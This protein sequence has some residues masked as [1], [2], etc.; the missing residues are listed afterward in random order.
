MLYNK[1]K[2][3][4]H[5]IS[6]M[7]REGAQ[8]FIMNI[9]RNID[10]EKIQ[11]D[12]LV[13]T[14][15]KC[16]YDDEIMS[17]GG[18]IFRIE[19]VSKYNVFKYSSKVSKT[20]NEKGPFISIHSHI[21]FFNGIIMKGAYNSKIPVRIAHSHSISDG[22]KGSCIRSLYKRYMR[23]LILKYSTNL[24]GCSTKACEYLYGNQ[25]YSDKRVKVINNGIEL[26]KYK[27][28][29]GN[30]H[31]LKERL[32]FTKDTL[33]IGHVGRF[34]KP[35][36]HLFII[37]IF[38]DLFKKNNK[39]KLILVGDGNLKKKVQNKIIEKGLEKD[40]LLLGIRKD[41]PQIMGALDVFLLPS[42]YEGLGIVLVE[43][44]SAGIPCIT[45]NTVPDDAD[46]GMGLIKKLDLKS[47]TD[48]WS[49]AILNSISKE[50]NNWKDIYRVIQNK[51]YDV[52][53][54]S[55][56][57]EEIYLNT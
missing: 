43:A 26:D 15:E 35:K 9:Y 8:T 25:V 34:H 17:M 20:I 27:G 32:G 55:K 56:L 47:S 11:F 57:L 48:I 33:L 6:N 14:N 37:D 7:K 30:K 19:K 46:M 21:M 13:T 41:I 1:P 5:V 39:A 51:E 28:I 40:I 54:V 10:R 22:K 53:I 42:L 2:R 4:L 38:N 23:K 12:F 50:Q 3:V 24:F 44:Q 49:N 45:S 29:I 18:K 36:N 16:S 31:G 52:K